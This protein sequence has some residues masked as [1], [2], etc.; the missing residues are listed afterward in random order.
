MVLHI[1]YPKK[2]NQ[3]LSINNW[4]RWHWATRHKIKT[5]FR[6]LVKN[7]FLEE[8]I[9]PMSA[10]EIKVQLHRKGYRKFDAINLAIAIKIFEDC[11][12]ELNY[13]EDDD[14][15]KIIIEPT[16]LGSDEDILEINIREID[17]G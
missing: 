7:W 3:L 9:E 4:N 2:G 15:N 12:T 11:L 14:R 5:Q 13:I 8:Q 6:E 10:V 16:S 17:N 1:P